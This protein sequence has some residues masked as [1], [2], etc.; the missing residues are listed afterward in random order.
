MVLVYMTQI[1]IG[2]RGS[3]LALIQTN[4]VKEK[5]QKLLPEVTINVQIITTKGDKNMSPVPLDS[6]GKG[7]FTKEIDKALLDGT[8][9]IAVHSLKDLPE[10]LPKGLVIAAIPEREDARE[11][12]V[13]QNNVS[14][15]K[16]PKGAVIGTDS[17]RRKAQILHKRQ[18]LVVES[19][20][21][22]VNTRLE[23]LDAGQ[24]DALFLAVAGLKR[25]GLENRITEYFSVDDIIPSPGQGALAV[26]MKKSNTTLFSLLEKL[27]HKKTLSAISAEHVFSKTVGGGC[28]LPVGVYAVSHGNRIS[29]YGV[30]G[31]L[32]GTYVVKESIDGN[33]SEAKHLAKL[34]A[35]DLL[36][37]SKPW[38]NGGIDHI[39]SG[40][41]KKYVV[42]TRPLEVSNELQRK[43]EEMKLKTLSFPSIAIHKSILTKKIQKE[44]NNISSFDWIL[45][46]S[47][48]GVRFFMQ[49][50]E[51]LGID[52]SLLQKKYIAAVGPKTAEEVK[53][54][55]L[56]V[57]FIPSEFTTE[58]LSKGLQEVKDKR[59]LLPRA[60]IATST[61]T[62]Q[63]EKKGALVTNIAIYN[64]EFTRCESNGFE[65]LLDN[66]QIA[67]ITF[68][69]P[70]TIT[71]FLKNCE[72]IK[73]KSAIFSLPV[74]AI[75]PVTGNALK[76][77]GFQ[78]IYTA[79]TFTV[80][81]M[82]SKLKESIL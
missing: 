48:N 42:V 30:I 46:T 22:N 37:K 62:K 11:A 16:L 56:P 45:F 29:L 6:I 35:K 74:L 54:Y 65:D 10:V 71:G 76:H 20:R 31:S 77:H 17:T 73:N 27:N 19:V 9:D 34:L 36:A 13:S 59:I 80:E 25:L 49:A 58:D 18:D 78:K 52:T 41:T 64:T 38:Y 1:I 33:L 21:G 66:K 28:K 70:S 5:L 72:T 69:S 82:V 57:H 51:E 75:G 24:Y 68:T 81:G 55:Q 26:V 43:L 60:D 32:D 23:K 47:R 79:D 63:L 44:L 50:L 12:L 61:L 8:I 40:D 53:K 4:I 15:D 39:E 3:K 7:W 14:F 67:C 2:T